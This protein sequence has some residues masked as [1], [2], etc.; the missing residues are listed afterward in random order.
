MTF[1]SWEIGV[2]DFIVGK[3]LESSLVCRL[4]AA[5]VTW[6]GNEWRGSRIIG[7][8]L[9]QGWGE[10]AAESSIFTRAWLFFHKCLCAVFEK[11]RLTK[12]LRGS[13]FSMPFIWSFAALVLAPIMPT[14][15]ILVISLV[16]IASLVIAFGCD[17]DRRLVYSP[18]NKFVLLFAFVY[19]AATLTSVSVSGSLLG[20]ALTTLFVLFTVVI[21]NSVTTR[22][23]LDTLIYVFVVSGAV[24]SAYGIYQYVYGA[25]SASA[26]LDRTMF[27]G[28]GV[29][30]YSTLDN[31][32]MLAEYLLLVIPF[33][34]ASILIAK[35]AIPKL[36]F[37]G[38][39][40]VMLLC[41]VLTFARGGWL[42]LVI[43]AAVF[44][45]MLDRR[46]IIVGIIALVLLYF[47]LPGVIL[48][49][50]LSIGDIGDSSTSYR[51]SIWLATLTMLRDYWFTGIGPGTAAF[52]R[53]YPLY[54]FNT[55][56]APHSHN[57][58]LQ[59]MCDSGVCGIV[60][61]L[62]IIFTYFRSLCSAISRENNK[63]RGRPDKALPA[64]NT[65][66]EQSREQQEM[67]NSRNSKILQIAS[68]SSVLGFLV[69]GATDY[70]FYNYRVTLVFWAVLGLGALCA[71]RG[72]LERS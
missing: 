29:R 47:T 28:I 72:I 37:T 18:I 57:L 14:M 68:I 24:V 3:I 10:R 65:F 48:D 4:I 25:V 66:P 21:Q 50:F 39:F 40:G 33:A 35:G 22:R 70:S 1:K 26:W 43:A 38:C 16:C 69:Q 20:G 32:N 51:V 8:F 60:V 31:P 34:G 41:M 17:R 67:R 15:A 55:V 27:S 42:G 2:T 53:I 23:Q 7:R 63:K 54:S 52:N 9:S 11:L 61:F 49:R 12:L 6:F 5:V 62:A 58:F 30:V 44:L 56:S 13:I 45:I 71:R 36:F 19:I 64:S 46:F 59:I